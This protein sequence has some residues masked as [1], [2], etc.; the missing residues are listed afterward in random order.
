ML[1]DEEE[2]LPDEEGRFFGGGI[3]NNTS[4]VLDFIDERDKDEMAS[5]KT[6]LSG[7]IQKLTM[8]TKSQR[9]ST[10]HGYGSLL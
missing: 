4:D 10:Q 3:T 7:S 1:F 2:A 8:S 5:L 9:R 6:A